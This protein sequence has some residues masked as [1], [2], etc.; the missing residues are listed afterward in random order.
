MSR[1]GASDLSQVREV[2]IGPWTTSGGG[3]HWVRHIFVLREND[4]DNED[5][6]EIVS[7]ERWW[8]E[9][10]RFKDLPTDVTQDL[11]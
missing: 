8:D 10:L 2:F 1:H 3:G 5:L 11:E 6:S 9:G 4:L 7:K